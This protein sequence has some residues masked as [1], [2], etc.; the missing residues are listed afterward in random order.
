MQDG[1]AAGN[2]LVPLRLRCAGDEVKVAI[3][4]HNQLVAA[5]VRAH[6]QRL[7]VADDDALLMVEAVVAVDA[8]DGVEA[9]RHVVNVA[10]LLR[11]VLVREARAELAHVGQL[12]ARGHD[13][14]CAFAGCINLLQIL[15]PVGDVNLDVDGII[16]VAAVIG[17]V[18]IRVRQVGGNLDIPRNWLEIGCV[19]RQS[20]NNQQR[21]EQKRNQAFH[22]E[23]Y[24]LRCS[25]YQT[26]QK[27]K[28]LS[29]AKI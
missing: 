12:H 23:M 16:M 8:H 21:A 9:L 27:G 1:A 20:G 22:R 3:F 29:C 10:R 4:V 28:T 17:Q 14:R 24:L 2:V 19:L 13:G 25:T 11:R 5:L 7:T 18:T 26:N 6:P 15:R